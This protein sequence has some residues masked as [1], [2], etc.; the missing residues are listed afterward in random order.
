MEK[1]KQAETPNRITVGQFMSW[2]GNMNG[3][4]IVDFPREYRTERDHEHVDF[5]PTGQHYDHPI[6]MIRAIKTNSPFDKLEIKISGVH[7][8]GE[9]L[10]W[11]S[12]KQRVT[13]DQISIDRNN[14]TKVGTRRVFNGKMDLS[15]EHGALVD[16]F[17]LL[18]R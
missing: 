4:N 16:L 15:A 11:E 12:A 18:S 13:I 10:D 14:W 6:N 2:F 9:K 17:N 3:I 1:E 5:N 8:V 7:S